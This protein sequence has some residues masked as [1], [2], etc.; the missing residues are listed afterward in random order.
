[1]DA[2]RRISA[3]HDI[4]N[5]A[6]KSMAFDLAYSANSLTDS[7]DGISFPSCM[8][9]NLFEDARQKL[10]LA[11]EITGLR[12]SALAVAAGVAV[13]TITRPINRKTDNAPAARTM[14]LVDQVV[15][16]AIQAMP[17]VQAA[18][19]LRRWDG[20]PNASDYLSPDRDVLR[21]AVRAAMYQFRHVWGQ[22]DPE[23]LSDSILGTYREIIENE[24]VDKGE[25]S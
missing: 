1:M 13:T 18:E 5:I 7:G 10:V 8:E 25:C 15:R 11:C 2:S 9:K 17:A 4:S 23:I 14:A 22:V 20:K 6:N 16:D 12:P 21:Q 3:E 19:A 24:K